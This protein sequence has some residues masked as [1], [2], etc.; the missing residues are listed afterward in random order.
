LLSSLDNRVD[1]V[2]ALAPV[3]DWTA[4]RP[5]EP[6]DYLRRVICE[7]Y[8]GC[9]RFTQTDWERIGRGKLAQPINFVKEFNPQKLFII[10]AEDD[11]VVSVEQTRQFLFQVNSRSRFL[12]RGGHLS[13][14][15]LMHWPLSRAVL[16]F[17]S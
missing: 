7:G 9:Y 6:H 11:T 5:E 13:S 10:H 4:S 12:S 8:G 2:V 1:R 16:K 3:T 15:R 17:L 14:N